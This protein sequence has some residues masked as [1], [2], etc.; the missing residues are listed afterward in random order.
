VHLSIW[1]KPDDE[2]GF[3]ELNPVTARLIA[4]IDSNT[5]QRSGEELLTELGRELHYADPQQFLQH[6]RT[7]LEDLRRSGIVIGTRRRN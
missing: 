5:E 4:T 6:G 2:L 3:M 7:A 1:R